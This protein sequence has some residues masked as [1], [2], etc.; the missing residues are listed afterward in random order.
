MDRIPV[1]VEG[2][3]T[4]AVEEAIIP[5]HAPTTDLNHHLTM[6]ILPSI[7][8][9]SL[10]L[11]TLVILR[12][13]TSGRQSMAMR[14]L[15]THMRMRTYTLTPPPQSH[16]RITTPATLP[17]LIPLRSIL[18]NLL[19]ARLSRILNHTPRQQ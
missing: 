15:N 10:L 13:S 17:S 14:L 2:A 12:L 11:P 1:V 9:N 16:P 6:I 8:P 18:L 7:I 5:R 3:V 19:M 4:G